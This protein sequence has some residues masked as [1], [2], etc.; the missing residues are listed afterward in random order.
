MDSTA[1][2]SIEQAA[3]GSRTGRLHFGEVVAL[4]TRAGV[5][6][7]AADYRAG[8]TTYYGPDDATCAIALDA[9]D[10]PIAQRFDAAALQAAI[11][12]AQQGTVAYPEFKRL[13]RL[14]GCVG[15]TVWIAGRHVSY[16][17]R[18]GERH[19]EPFPDA[20]A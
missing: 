12:A 4:L 11:R 20:A 16:Q 19:V 18:R 15:Y 14:A 7:Y 3:E 8:R 10:V 6:S 17:G 2:R 1:R 9:P 5:E 13:S